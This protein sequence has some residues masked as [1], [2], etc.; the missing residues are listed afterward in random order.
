[1]DE[2]RQIDIEA[3]TSA[4]RQTVQRSLNRAVQAGLN[5]DGVY[6]EAMRDAIAEYQDRI[7]AETTGIL[8]ASQYRKLTFQAPP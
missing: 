2:N 8:T 6:S 3:A 4:V 1:L 7:N 5:V